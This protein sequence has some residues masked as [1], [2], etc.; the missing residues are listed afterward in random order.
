VDGPGRNGQSAHDDA[1]LE[2]VT[3][4]HRDAAVA[5]ARRILGDHALAEDAVQHA[6]EQ[7]LAYVRAHDADRVVGHQR[8]AVLRGTRWA[9]LK[10][11]QRQRGRNAAE[12]RAAAP[13]GSD[14]AEWARAEGASVLA[15]ILA[16]LPRHY[17]DVLRLRFLEA[18]PDRVGAETL[19]LSVKAYRRRLDRALVRARSVAGELG[20]TGRGA[21]LPA[22]GQRGGP[23]GWAVALDIRVRAVRHRLE[24]VPPGL[25]ASLAHMAMAAAVVGLTLG[26]AGGAAVVPHSVLSPAASRANVAAG[27][28]P[29]LGA[30]LQAALTQAGRADP[31]GPHSGGAAPTPLP[32][33]PTN[34]LANPAL[35]PVSP[36]GAL[37]L[38]IQPAPRFERTHALVAVAMGYACQC[39]L[40][41]T[42]PDAGATWTSFSLPVNGSSQPTVVLPP[43]YP[44]D[45]R[46]FL[47][48]PLWLSGADCVLARAGATTCD[49][50]PLVGALQVDAAF[51]SGF[52]VVY[53]SEPNVGVVAYDVESHATHVLAVNPYSASP[54]AIAAPTG[55]VPV[56]LYIRTF[57]GAGLGG[58]TVL[59]ACA[60]DFTCAQRNTVEFLGQVAVDREDRGG[61]V[62]LAGAS[63][64]FAA[65]DVSVDGGRSFASVTVD[66]NMVMN[67]QFAGTADRLTTWALTETTNSFDYSL[68]WSGWGSGRWH[69][70]ALPFHPTGSVELAVISGDRLVV[71]DTN[72]PGFWCTVDLGR[73]WGHRCPPA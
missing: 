46:V 25:T 32:K 45:P 21:V 69:R 51:D 24:A 22:L 42:S 27:S 1:L 14:E 15:G 48:Y 59:L 4:D 61:N 60:R 49:P 68:Y 33:P 8:D 71:A 3:R 13:A 64:T 5:Y 30:P 52:P 34:L 50:L 37:F 53:A 18:Q 26:I 73:T 58:A 6:L 40:G 54:P 31:P 16:R 9:A 36:D 66:G 70:L 67:V 56:A 20:I 19:G 72:A 63:S 10:L 43:A 29:P 44:D 41:F 65:V 47:A 38:Q 55:V 11:I 28:A 17:R 12:R 7:L 2:A 35:G 23:R 39:I 62:L 57:G